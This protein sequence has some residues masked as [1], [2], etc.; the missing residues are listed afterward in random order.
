MHRSS[1]VK[2]LCQWWCFPISDLNAVPAE[3]AAEQLWS[4]AVE[5]EAELKETKAK[6]EEH[7][8]LTGDVCHD[9]M[10]ALHCTCST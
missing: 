8:G 10:C 2:L 5:K 9:V 4:T 1:M 7:D 3:A 6:L